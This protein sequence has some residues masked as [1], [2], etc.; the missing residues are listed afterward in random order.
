MLLWAFV[1]GCAIHSQYSGLVN[2]DQQ[3]IYLIPP[4]GKVLTLHSDDDALEMLHGCGLKVE[5]NRLLRHLWVQQW[6]VTDAGDGSQPFVGPLR[7]VGVQ[8]VVEDWNTGSRIILEPES[9]GDLT[10]H[11]GS[12]VMIA[13]VIVGAHQV[14]VIS[15]RVLSS[16]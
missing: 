3:Q 9:V 15:M 12:T 14:R 10:Q 8:W 4:T 5:A 2:V 16:Q 11:I 1:L 7:R 13:G 6:Q